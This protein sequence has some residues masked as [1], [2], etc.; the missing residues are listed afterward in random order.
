MRKLNTSVCA[1][2]LSRCSASSRPCS[3]QAR[4]SLPRARSSP[5][6]AQPLAT[7]WTRERCMTSLRSRMPPW[8][9]STEG[10]HAHEK[11]AVLEPEI[12]S[13]NTRALMYFG[14]APVQMASLSSTVLGAIHS[15]DIQR[16]IDPTVKFR[17]AKEPT[18]ALFRCW[19]QTSP[20]HSFK[21]L[22]VKEH[23]RSRLT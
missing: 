6:P 22:V 19:N 3:P 17:S 20:R 9:L 11:Y 4:Q 16:L 14:L 18:F 8:E 13:S 1:A 21:S 7:R 5:P 23:E 15:I 2:S 12:N 10:F